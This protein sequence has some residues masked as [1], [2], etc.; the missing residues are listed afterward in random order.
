M[1][2]KKREI[3]NFTVTNDFNSDYVYT[4]LVNLKISDEVAE[5]IIK[6][7]YQMSYCAYVQGLANEHSVLEEQY[8]NAEITKYIDSLI[9]DIIDKICA[10]D[11]DESVNEF[12]NVYHQYKNNLEAV[13]K[14]PL[15]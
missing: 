8:P 14:Q 2:S 11:N 3:A 12:L 13:E 6:L 15:Q 4:T 10:S 1:Q 9:N 5:Q 7:L